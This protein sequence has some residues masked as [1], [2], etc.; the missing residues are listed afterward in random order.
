MATA[1]IAPSCVTSIREVGIP[2]PR[3]LA[4]SHAPKSVTQ[5]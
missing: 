3:N 4:A 2:Q 5:P 1:A